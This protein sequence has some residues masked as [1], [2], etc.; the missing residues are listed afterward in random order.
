VEA[1]FVLKAEGSMLLYLLHTTDS[2][3]YAITVAI[4]LNTLF[5]TSIT[6]NGS[7]PL[8]CLH[9][10]QRP[11]LRFPSIQTY[12][13]FT[14]SQF[15]IQPHQGDTRHVVPPRKTQCIHRNHD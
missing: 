7:G 6:R 5:V 15:I 3:S 2:P 10:G 11:I 4:I 12:L 13:P 1:G 9:N 14:R 8:S